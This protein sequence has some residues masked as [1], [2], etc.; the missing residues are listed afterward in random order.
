MAGTY[1]LSGR[2]ALI[3]GSTSGIGQATAVMLAAS[4][5]R[6]LVSGRDAQRGAAV[7]ASIRA[8]GGVADFLQGDLLDRASALR[9]VDAAIGVGG[10]IDILVNNATATAYGGT[11]GFA[12][13]DFD[14]I[15]GV[16]LKVPFYLVGALA[17]GMAARGRGAIVNL[18]SIAGRV[19]MPIV[20]V[21]GASKAALELMT[22]SWAAEYGPDGVRVN[23]VSP[24]TAMT[25]PVLAMSEA[26][27]E[28]LK[29]QS[30]LGRVGEP[31]E[32]AAAITYLASDAASYVNGVILQVDGGR[33]NL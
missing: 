32:V 24:G 23:A 6:V 30:L 29:H 7:V 1:D 2:T 26:A 10:Q 17:P 16:N 31:E 13:D 22:Q 9:L 15:L 11:E 14:R 8:A 25:P 18:S 21:Y 3:T 5:A 20:G 4:G 33:V 28:R 12:E 19:G 27:R